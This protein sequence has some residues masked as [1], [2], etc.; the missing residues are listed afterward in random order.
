V[1]ATV[2]CSLKKNTT[3][4]VLHIGGNASIGKNEKCA[5]SVR[6]L[7]GCN[8]SLTTFNMSYCE[9]TDDSAL[10]ISEGLKL[11][12]TLKTITLTSS[13]SLTSKGMTAICS[14]LCGNP[15]LTKFDCS[16]TSMKPDSAKE[17]G[18]LLAC[19]SSLEDLSL[20]CNYIGDEGLKYICEGLA[21]NKS[22]K[23]VDFSN[24]NITAKGME[25]FRTLLVN[26][27][28]I[29][30]SYVIFNSNTFG[31][32]GMI[33]LAEGLS[34]NTSITQLMLSSVGLTNAG[35]MRLFETLKKKAGRISWIYISSNPGITDK[36]LE[37]A[38]EKACKG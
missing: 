35:A 26:S 33:F 24:C 14:A 38:I 13:P 18:K 16:S 19:S 34:A 2:L 37:E 3:L 31:D 1:N 32:A 9:L 7:L 21:K 17:I 29:K 20:S 6:E 4:K 30:L 25:H 22:V 15:V 10:I 23:T 36:S 28:A 12:K 8:T 27:K 5:T 11:N